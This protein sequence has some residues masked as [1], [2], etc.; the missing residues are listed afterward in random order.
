[1]SGDRIAE[2]SFIITRSDLLAPLKEQVDKLMPYI[3]EVL[4]GALGR[5]GRKA[6]L[7]NVR[8]VSA[9]RGWWTKEIKED[10]W[11]RGGGGWMVGK[12]NVGKSNLFEVVFPKGRGGAKEV[13][14]RKIRSAAEREQM[15]AAAKS[16]EELVQIQQQLAEEDEEMARA[17]NG[18]EQS[19]IASSTDNIIEEDTNA[20]FDD[21]DAFHLLPPPQPETPFPTMPVISSLPGTTASPIRIP[22]GNKRGELID[23][24]GLA[25][26]TPSLETF[27]KPEERD[28]LV[29]KHRIAPEK[30][31]IK[32]G[33]SLLLGGGL[34]RITPKTEGLVFI[35]HPFVPLPT[36]ITSLEKA[37]AMQ[38]Q[39]RES[40]IKTIMQEGVGSKIKP[41]GIIQLKWDVTRKLAGPLTNPKAGKMKPENLPFAIYSADILIEGVGWVELVAQIRKPKYTRSASN[42]S[43]TA[44]RLLDPET[45][46]EREPDAFDR[47]EAENSALSS[48]SQA[49]HSPQIPFPEVEIFTPEGKFIGVRQPMSAS[50]LGGPKP[51]SRNERKSRPRRSMRSLKL[52]QRG[53]E[54]KAEGAAAAGE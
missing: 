54:R 34:I 27:V 37:E 9:M 43:D 5:V 13:N 44:F 6:R 42:A 3:Q 53:R 36:H 15:Q 30:S 24:P 39:T 38:L 26:T 29:M 18:G 52:S 19:S 2:V 14:V 25:R 51:K 8:L 33:Q 28:S 50:V 11:Q 48:S 35:A 41:A 46:N 7:G 23:L 22:F 1:M 45:G 40:N 32:P 31:V 12:V 16:M 21:L 47:A 17:A 4:R 10:I 20:G 49:D